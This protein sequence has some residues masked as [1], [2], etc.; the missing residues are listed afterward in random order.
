MVDVVSQPITFSRSGRTAPN[1]FL[2][3][4]IDVHCLSYL[5]NSHAK[6]TSERDDGAVVHVGRQKPGHV[7]EAH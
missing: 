1:R 5:G 7:R 2:K 4:A 3:V 6:F